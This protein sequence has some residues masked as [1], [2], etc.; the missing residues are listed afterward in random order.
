MKMDIACT[1]LMTPVGTI[2]LFEIDDAI[3]VLEWGQAPKGVETPLLIEAK[4]QISAYFSAQLTD[5]DLPLNPHGTDHQIKVWNKMRDIPFGET[6]TYGEIA[7]EIG[8]AAQAVGGACGRNPIP[9]LIPC[10]RI[11]GTNGKMTGYSGGDG[12]ETKEQL[13]RLEQAV[14]TSRQ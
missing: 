14:L 7:K 6:R 11:V 13:L 10:H 8:S 3:G 2:S 9:L 12:I 4:K 1:S 5:F